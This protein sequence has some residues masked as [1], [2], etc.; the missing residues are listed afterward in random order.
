MIWKKLLLEIFALGGF[1]GGIGGYFN[2][3][4]GAFK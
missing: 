4:G 2:R 1:G 3:S